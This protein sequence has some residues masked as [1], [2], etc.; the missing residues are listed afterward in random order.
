MGVLLEATLFVIFEP[1]IFSFLGD[2]GCDCMTTVR[3]HPP[4]TKGSQPPYEADGDLSAEQDRKDQWPGAVQSTDVAIFRALTKCQ[5]LRTAEI[6]WLLEFRQEWE[7]LS[8]DQVVKT[9]MD[10]PPSKEIMKLRGLKTMKLYLFMFSFL[11][12]DVGRKIEAV[13]SKVKMIVEESACSP[14]EAGAGLR[15]TPE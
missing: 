13:K 7:H 9:I 4:W 2:F 1:Q 8:T 11:Y 10:L 6:N 15:L 5:N 14:K 12:S 3:V